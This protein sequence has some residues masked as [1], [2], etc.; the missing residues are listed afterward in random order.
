MAI[1]GAL[2]AGFAGPNLKVLDITTLDADTGPTNIAHGM[3]GTPL[4]IPMPQISAAAFPGWIIIPAATNVAVT[5]LN[6]AGSGGA[7]P[8]TTVAMKVLLLTPHSIMQ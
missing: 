8:G 1:A 4:A 5:K 6:A 2:E 7:V 3:A